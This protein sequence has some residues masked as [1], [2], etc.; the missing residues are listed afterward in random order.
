LDL[1]LVA[2]Q[3]TRLQKI[4]ESSEILVSIMSSIY[5]HS[6][7]NNITECAYGLRYV[8]LNNYGQGKDPWSVRQTAI[9][10]KYEGNTESWVFI[11]ASDIFETKVVEHHH[12]LKVEDPEKNN[13]FDFHLKLI[14]SA[15]PNWRWYIK[16]LVEKATE[17]S[18]RVVAAT[19]GQ[20]KL[21]SII[22]FEINFED[23]QK[24][25]VVEGQALDMLTIFESTSDTITSILQEYEFVN[26]GYKDSRSDRTLAGLRDSLREVELYRKKVEVLCKRI[27]STASLVCFYSIFDRY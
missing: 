18:A 27:Q 6:E 2:S 11:S 5:K 7:S 15:L 16:G 17:Q 12:Q 3:S 20:G 22:D 10:H 8:E 26:Y 9:Y 14:N 1:L 4:V 21:S 25:L 19:V 13:P 24:L 23:R